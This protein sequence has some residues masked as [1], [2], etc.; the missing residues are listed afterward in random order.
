MSADPILTVPPQPPAQITTAPDD[1]PDFEPPKLRDPGRILFTVEPDPENPGKKLFEPIDHDGSAFW[2][3]E[4]GFMDYWLESEVGDLERGA[5]VMEGIVGSVLRGDGWT[6]GDS[7]R[8][9]YGEVRPAT[10]TEIQK[11]ALADISPT[12]PAA[13]DALAADLCPMP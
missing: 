6:C 13:S 8:W 1:G 7:E 4:G 11:Q 10:D 12:T 9:E 3:N 2:I 5:Y